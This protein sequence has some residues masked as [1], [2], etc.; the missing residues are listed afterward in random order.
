MSTV[1]Q[2]KEILQRVLGPRADELAR[3][4]GFVQ[5][6]RKLSGASF[7]QGLVFA[8][9]AKQNP[10]GEEVREL[11]TRKEVEI[12]DSGLSQ[13]LQERAATLLRR[14][15]DELG[16]EPL[17]ASQP[18]PVELFQ[19]FE[20]VI[21]ED[22]TTIRLPPFLAHVWAGCGGGQGQSKAGLK[23][24]V[25]W[26]LKGGGMAGPL[27]TDAKQ[28]DQSSP[29]RQ[30]GIP[31]GV[32]NITDEGYCSL[33]WLKQQ[34]GFFLTRPRSTVVFLDPDMRQDLDLEV[35]GPKVSNGSW[36]GQVLVGR[37][38]RLPARLLLIPVSEEVMPKRRER[39][40]AEAKRR[41]R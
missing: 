27:L 3:E 4:T 15:L 38:A 20:A 35:I 7:A 39:L 34:K 18:A 14:L 37:D 10:T 19:S 33:E 30:Q 8:C 17:S 41:G 25:R 40:R 12:S 29:M 2:I 6:R 1:P 32:L 31:A 28:A 13:H 22:S 24:H 23:L 16:S 21:V 5:R 11:L 9:L 36:Q 26:D